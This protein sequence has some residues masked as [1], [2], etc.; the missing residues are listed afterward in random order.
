[1]KKNK[2]SKLAYA[3]TM[4]EDANWQFGYYNNETD[5]ISTFIVDKCISLNESQEIFK[6]P[7]DKVKCINLEE[8]K[9]NFEKALEKAE[10]TRKKYYPN[11]TVNKKIAILQNIKQGQL[12]NITFV[13]HSFKTINIKINALNGKLIRHEVVSLF[14][15]KA[16]AE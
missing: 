1:N 6:K 10:Q 11:E 5:M 9:I 4:D 7:G 14:D 16:K 3:F 8:V 2:K 12:W 15:F 13:T